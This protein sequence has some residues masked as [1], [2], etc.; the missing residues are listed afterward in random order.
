MKEHFNNLVQKVNKIKNMCLN[1]SIVVN[2]LLSTKSQNL[3][4][5][6][7]KFNLLLFEFLANDICGEGVRNINFTEFVD[8]E[9]GVLKEEYGVW[10]T[11]NNNYSKRDILHLDNLG[12]RLLARI[13]RDSVYRRIRIRIRIRIYN[14]A[15]LGISIQNCH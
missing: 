6:V 14:N 12:I 10:D 1:S 3:N 7:L 9:H 8:N 15:S 5:C 2:P 4:Q 11:K 13:M